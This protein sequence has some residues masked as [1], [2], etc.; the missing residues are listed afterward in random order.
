[1]MVAPT[2]RVVLSYPNGS[3][4]THDVEGQS[5]LQALHRAAVAAKATTAHVLLLDPRHQALSTLAALGWTSRPATT[6]D[7]P[8]YQVD[9]AGNHTLMLY[10]ARCRYCQQIW[11]WDDLYIPAT[12]GRQAYP[13]WHE[14]GL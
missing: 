6:Q 3:T 14:L 13:A 10:Q 7:C 1:M 9:I 5:G 12:V 11:N 2:H 8:H 4:S